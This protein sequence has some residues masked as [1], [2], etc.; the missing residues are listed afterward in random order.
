MLLLL[1][2]KRPLEIGW[3]QVPERSSHEIQG[4]NHLCFLALVGLNTGEV[5]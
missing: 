5:W 2:R 1:H 4:E 3:A